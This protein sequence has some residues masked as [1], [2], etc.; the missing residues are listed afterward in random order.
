M[1]KKINVGSLLHTSHLF[2]NKYLLKIYL[3]LGIKRATKGMNV[4]FRTQPQGTCGLVGEIRH[5][6]IHKS[7]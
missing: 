2:T 3:V 1:T 4:T 6:S 5:M 7:S